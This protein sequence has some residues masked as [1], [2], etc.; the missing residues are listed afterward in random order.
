MLQE[1]RRLSI[2]KI[3]DMMHISYGSVEDIIH[4]DLG[5]R[6]MAA[7]RPE[8]AANGWILHQD[9]APAHRAIATQETIAQ[10]GIEIMPHPPYSPD[11]APCDFY[12]FPQVKK[13]FVGAIFELIQN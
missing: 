3:A 6:K 4:N 7:K 8:L 9:N 5:Y 12:L 2:M 13:K 1:D 11:L 10:L